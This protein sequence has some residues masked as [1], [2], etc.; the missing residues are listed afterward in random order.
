MRLKKSKV[1]DELI[2]CKRWRDVR[3]A[4]LTEHPLCERCKREGIVRAATEV[5]H[6]LEVELGRTRVEMEA[7]AYSTANL[8]ALCR[9]CHRAEHTERRSHSRVEHQKREEAREA[10]WRKRIEDRRTGVSILSSIIKAK[11]DH[12]I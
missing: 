7:R 10:V 3:A 12:N 8:Q 4:Y 11:T 9:E 2:Q 6:L 1:Y 5:H